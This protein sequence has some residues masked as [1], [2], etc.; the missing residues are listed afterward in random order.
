[1]GFSRQNTR[2]GSYF[3]LRGFSWSRDWTQVS[4]IAGRSFA[5]WATTEAKKTAQPQPY[6]VPNQQEPGCFWEE[7]EAMSILKN[8][9]G[10]LCPLWTSILQ[11]M[12]FSGF[13]DKGLWRVR[14]MS[15]EG[16]GSWDG[17]SLWLLPP[18]SLLFRPGWDPHPLTLVFLGQ[19]AW[20][21]ALWAS[22]CPLPVKRGWGLGP[23]PTAETQSGM[24]ASASRS[25]AKWRWDVGTAPAR[26][27]RPSVPSSPACRL[28]SCGLLTPVCLSFYRPLVLCPPT[29]P[30][31]SS[32]C[33]ILVPL[34]ILTLLL[35]FLFLCPSP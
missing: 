35:S 6:L 31:L 7:P 13:W 34:G 22:G 26:P 2:V 19:W 25:R 28:C 23:S 4:C 29:H 15:Q 12:T 10:G 1:M 27:A 30:L 9:Q 3:F 8:R 21:T 11:S 18:H 16:T 32:A 5:V 24:K 33:L 17:A 14:A 20:Q